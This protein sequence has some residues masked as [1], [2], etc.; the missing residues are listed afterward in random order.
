MG[1]AI[2]VIASA[3]AVL[4]TAPPAAA[5]PLHLAEFDQHRPAFAGLNLR[6]PLGAVAQPRPVLRLQVVAD[7]S[8]QQRRD[9]SSQRLRPKGFEIGLSST[10]RPALFVNGQPASDAQNRLGMGDTGGNRLLI[11]GGV[12]LAV[13]VIAVVAGGAG[14]G[15]T[16]PTVN[17]SRDHCINP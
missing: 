15:D 1:K 6:L 9:P 3:L 14:P 17:G 12:V 4:A 5:Q 2:I 7:H 10:G 13:V 16:C 11:V 8:A